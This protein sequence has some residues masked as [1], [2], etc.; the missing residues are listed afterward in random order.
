MFN[1]PIVPDAPVDGNV[2]DASDSG[3]TEFDDS[4]PDAESKKTNT[5]RPKFVTKPSSVMIHEG[6]NLINALFS[7]ATTTTVPLP[8][9]STPP[10]TIS[11]SSSQVT[12]KTQRLIDTQRSQLLIQQIQIDSLSATLDQ[13]LKNLATQGESSCRQDILRAHN[14]DEDPNGTQGESEHQIASTMPSATHEGDSGAQGESGS[15]EVVGDKGKGKQVTGEEIEGD[16]IDCSINLG[17]VFI[18]EWESEDEDV[19]IEFEKDDERSKYST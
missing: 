13:V 1:D 14:D 10:T 15:G 7:T 3:S 4:D 12:P 2:E 18:E 19:E 17:N 6:M 8:S 9:V 16:K 11:T 5:A